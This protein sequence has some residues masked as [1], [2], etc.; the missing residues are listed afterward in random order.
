VREHGLVVEE[1]IIACGH[2]VVDAC[3]QGSQPTQC[4]DD[5]PT[6]LPE[7]LGNVRIAGRLAL[8]KPGLEARLYAIE[9]DALQEDDMKMDMQIEGPPKR[10]INVTDPGWTLCRSLPLLTAWFT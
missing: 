9:V 6:D 10:W 2:G 8:D 1:E 4:A 5:P 3:R 7:D